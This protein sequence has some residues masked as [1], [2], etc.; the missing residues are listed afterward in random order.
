MSC[1]LEGGI[2][3]DFWR[4]T[5]KTKK[6][7]FWQAKIVA[8]FLSHQAVQYRCTGPGEGWC[9]GLVYRSWGSLNG[10]DLGACL[11]SVKGSFQCSF[12]LQ[13][14]WWWSQD[15][16]PSNKKVGNL[17]CAIHL[18]L[19]RSTAEYRVWWWLREILSPPNIADLCT[20]KKGPK[21]VLIL[22]TSHY[23]APQTS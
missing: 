14:N 9:T 10:Q 15:L 8:T 16:N 12:T 4:Y 11:P 19:Q 3:F 7:V 13:V 22:N 5:A 20:P 17:C 1:V 2:I 6:L 18:Y 23:Q 21:M